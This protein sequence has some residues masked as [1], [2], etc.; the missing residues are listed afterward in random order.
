MITLILPEKASKE[1]LKIFSVFNII[2]GHSICNFLSH[3]HI[4]TKGP[5][6]E[7]KEK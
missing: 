6:A 7:L 3:D 4:V 5:N 1:F 2:Y